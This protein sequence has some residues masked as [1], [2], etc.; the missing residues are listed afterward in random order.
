ML[1]NSSIFT[2][3]NS[4]IFIFKYS[5]SSAAFTS[6]IYHESDDPTW[7]C[8]YLWSFTIKHQQTNGEDFKIKALVSN[9][10]GLA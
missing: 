1:L 4:Q 2:F 3:N 9:P 5:S 8:E 7:T 10:G 6:F